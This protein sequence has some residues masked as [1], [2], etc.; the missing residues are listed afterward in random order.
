MGLKP[1]NA[2]S[3]T[4]LLRLY[5]PEVR[6]IAVAL[7]ATIHGVA[8]GAVEQVYM[9]WK[10]VGY[11]WS[12]GMKGAFCAIAP[13]KGHVNAQLWYG[14]QLK[15]PK[16]LLEGTGKMGRHVKLRS[17]TDAG[18]AALKALLKQAAS[19]AKRA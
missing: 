7:R 10:T 1:R 15:D 17:K 16:G 18:A 4:A 8:P 5:S 13:H 9:G 3:V 19:I 6:E 2:G 11:S 12:G 14:N